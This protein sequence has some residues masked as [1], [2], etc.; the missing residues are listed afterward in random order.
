MSGET[1]KEMVA[2]VEEALG[3]WCNE[4]GAVSVWAEYVINELHN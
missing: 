3:E 2:W 4:E 1:L